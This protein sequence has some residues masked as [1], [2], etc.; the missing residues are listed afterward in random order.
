MASLPLKSRFHYGGP[1][2]V[3]LD[4]AREVSR[5]LKYEG[6]AAFASSRSDDVNFVANLIEDLCA[7]LDNL[8]AKLSE[9]ANSHA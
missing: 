7:E 2:K 3:D 5:V 9:L 6:M 1:G 4:E 8:D